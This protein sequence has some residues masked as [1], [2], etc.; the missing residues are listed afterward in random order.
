M[1]ENEKVDIPILQ[2]S[3]DVEASQ[4]K[5]LAEL[6]QSRNQDDVAKSLEEIEVAARDG[7][8]LMP[9]FVRAANNYVTLGEMVEELKQQFGIYEESAVF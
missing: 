6:K 3:P 1:E 9:V 5:R 7:K 4:K 2:V 8:N